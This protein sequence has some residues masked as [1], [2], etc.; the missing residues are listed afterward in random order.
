MKR[1]QTHAATTENISPKV[2]SGS[3]SSGNT[4]QFSKQEQKQHTDKEW[5]Q[6]QQQN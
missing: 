1:Q 2:V 3:V 4:K 5:R 6:Q